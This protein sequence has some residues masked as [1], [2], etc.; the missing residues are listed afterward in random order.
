ME[1]YNFDF[2]LDAQHAFEHDPTMKYALDLFNMGKNRL[3]YLHISGETEGE[4]N[5]HILLDKSRNAK[6]II[7]FLDK[8]MSERESPIILEGEYRAPEEVAEEID[9]IR[10]Q[11]M[12]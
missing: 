5:N 4:G 11:L 10:N 2:V 6:Q 8:V 3:K 7:S 12:D 1:K 9:F